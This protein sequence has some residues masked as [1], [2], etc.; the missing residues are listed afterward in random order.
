MSRVG[1]RPI[2][3]P[4]GVQVE[5]NGSDIKV[6]GPKGE[7]HRSFASDVSVQKEGAELKIARSSDLPAVRALHGTTR[8]LLF[9]MV[10]GVTQGWSRVLQIEGVGYKAE[11]KG[12]NLVMALG[13]SHPVEIEPPAGI[14]FESDTKARL[15]T[16]KG[17]DKE[18]V[19]QVAAEIRAWR[20]PEPY[21]GKGVR[22]QGEY[23]R[24]KAGKAAKGGKGKGKK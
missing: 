20:P 13:F 18:Q 24:Q 5:I 16:V 22:Y 12:K 7:L 19:G 1:K 2:A 10:H 8:A 4:A 15:I 3:I 6:K 9:N 14:Q 11:M 23:V 21:K 17:P